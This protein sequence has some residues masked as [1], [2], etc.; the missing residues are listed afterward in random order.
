MRHLHFGMKFW[1]GSFFGAVARADCV[2]PGES[3]SEQPRASVHS[4]HERLADSRDSFERVPA[5]ILGEARRRVAARNPTRT[6]VSV[7]PT[8]RLW[9]TAAMPT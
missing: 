2:D 6:G 8:E 5:T 9:K 4:Q 7:C 3:R 1:L